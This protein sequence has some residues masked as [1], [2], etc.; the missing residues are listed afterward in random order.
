L[1]EI[2]KVTRFYGQSEKTIVQ[3]SDPAI[4]HAN[5]ELLERAKSGAPL[6]IPDLQDEYKPRELTLEYSE[7]QIGDQQTLA[8]NPKTIR[9]SARNAASRF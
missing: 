2:W 3:L 4:G 9:A 5:E 8:G 7:A 6:D 1:T